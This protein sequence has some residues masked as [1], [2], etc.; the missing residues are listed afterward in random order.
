MNENMSLDQSIYEAIE[1][2]ISPF[3]SEAPT[4]ARKFRR[5]LELKLTGRLLQSDLL[6]LI[7]EVPVELQEP[8]S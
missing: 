5:R 3:E 8:G 4:F 6:D 1:N 7:E 2:T